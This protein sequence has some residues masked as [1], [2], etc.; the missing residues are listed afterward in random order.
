MFGYAQ[1]AYADK[2][3]ADPGQL[4]PL[5][6]NLTFDQGAGTPVPGFLF[7]WTEYGECSRNLRHVADK[8]R[9]SRW[10]SSSPEGYANVPGVTLTNPQTP[11]FGLGEW[12]LVTAAAGGIGMS[13]VQIAKGTRAIS[14]VPTKPYR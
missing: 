10:A 7:P 1:G 12:V 5:P 4:L 11:S 8:L 2:V 9:G 13:A 3:L 6:K 14:R